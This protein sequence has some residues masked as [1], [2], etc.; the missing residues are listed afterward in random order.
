VGTGFVELGLL[1]RGNQHAR[2]LLSQRFGH[3]QA[4]AARAASDNGGP[5]GKRKQFLYRAHS[6]SA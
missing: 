4:Q 1:A 3:L 5:A 2:A 6:A